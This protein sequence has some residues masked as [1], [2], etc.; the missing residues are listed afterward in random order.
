[1]GLCTFYSRGV[2]CLQTLFEYNTR[3]LKYTLLL[4]QQG[5]E[6]PIRLSDFEFYHNKILREK[7]LLDQELVAEYFPAEV[8]VRR[9]LDIF[10]TLF[11]LTIQELD[12]LP[13]NCKWHP[14]VT[15][16]EVWEVDES[17]FIGYLYVDIY[18]RPGKFNHAA[19]FNIYPVS[20]SSL[21][22]ICPLTD[23]L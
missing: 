13:E 15:A 23:I 14:D 12:D 10:K 4:L 2:L 5:V 22:P 8:T 1:M 16:Y 21:V 18:P 9:M 3:T 19:N 11:A 20:T 6:T 7:Y 17:V